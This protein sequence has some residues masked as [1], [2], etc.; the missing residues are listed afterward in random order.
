MCR[1][2]SGHVDSWPRGV[3]LYT[4]PSAPESVFWGRGGGRVGGG[5]GGCRVS[6]PKGGG[7]R[8]WELRPAWPKK[9]GGVPGPLGPF[10]E[11]PQILP[12]GL[13][14]LVWYG[15]VWYGMVCYGMVWYGMVWSGM[16]WN[17]ML[18][19]L[20]LL[21][22]SA[23]AGGRNCQ[24]HSPWAERKGAVGRCN[25]GRAGADDDRGGAALPGGGGGGKRARGGGRSH[26]WVLPW[27][28]P[29]PRGGGWPDL[30]EAVGEEGGGQG[31][32]LGVGK[33]RPGAQSHRA[34]PEH[35]AEVAVPRVLPR[36]GRGRWPVSLAVVGGERRLVFGVSGY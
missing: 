9:P 28:P 18:L 2:V 16:L 27:S 35:P 8:R 5:G 20:L 23:G 29:P 6:P 32:D 26:L 1:P 31:V 7:G 22:R 3:G 14:Y 36:C 10:E 25:A 34:L 30:C 17:G 19:L 15:M 21:R 4:Q 12:G 11:K 24:T 33:A 13:R